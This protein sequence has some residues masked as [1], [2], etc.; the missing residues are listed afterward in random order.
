MFMEGS[1]YLMSETVLGLDK[2]KVLFM[3]YNVVRRPL[4]YVVI[5]GSHAY[6]LS[7]YGS[8]YDI[9]GFYYETPEEMLSFRPDKGGGYLCIYIKQTLGIHYSMVFVKWKRDSCLRYTLKFHMLV[10]MEEDTVI[11]TSICQIG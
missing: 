11:L 4:G 6:G 2:E 7:Y 5:S 1:E 9:R 3:V 8:D 10:I